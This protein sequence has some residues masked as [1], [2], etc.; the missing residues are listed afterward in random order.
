MTWQPIETA[1]KDTTSILAYP[2]YQVTHWST[3]CLTSDGHGWAGDWDE[4]FDAYFEVK[5]LT[6]WIPLPAPPEVAA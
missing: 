1:P 4:G 2:H 5:G 6:H 3:E